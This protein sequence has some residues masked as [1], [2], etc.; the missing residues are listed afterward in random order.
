MRWTEK[1]KSR[2]QI[3]LRHSGG[4]ETRH[5]LK[6]GFLSAAASME[7]CENHLSS[8]WRAW[9]EIH[10][11]AALLIDKFS[12]KEICACSF[13]LRFVCHDSGKAKIPGRMKNDATLNLITFN[14]V[15]SHPAKSKSGF[16]ICVSW[17]APFNSITFEA[18]W[19][20]TH[21]NAAITRRVCHT[22]WGQR[23]RQKHSFSLFVKKK[24]YLI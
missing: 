16:G 15:F 5:T 20:L 7:N 22:H 4:M 3:A 9:E 23:K 13:V 12:S 17:E 24:S 2:K 14:F 21:R 18:L 10:Y 19:A 1:T 6:V 8:F 11:S